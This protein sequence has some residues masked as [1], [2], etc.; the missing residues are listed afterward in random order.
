MRFLLFFLLLLLF[1]L[2]PLLLLHLQLLFLLLPLLPLLLLLLYP[3]YRSTIS[4]LLIFSSLFNFYSLSSTSLLP[5]S[6]FRLLF[7]LLPLLTF[8]I[9]PQLFPFLPLSYPIYT[10]PLLLP[11]L[12]LL[13]PSS[14]SSSLI[15]PPLLL[16]GQLLELHRGQG[17]EIYWRDGHICPDEQEYREMVRQSECVHALCFHGNHLNTRELLFIMGSLS[18]LIF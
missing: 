7:F 12:S 11:L 9:H 13:L 3:Y 1:L 8:L 5:S 4:Y 16:S 14:S 18:M 10:T 17:K 15:S 6:P 2:L